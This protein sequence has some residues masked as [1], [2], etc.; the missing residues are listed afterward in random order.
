MGVEGEA[1]AAEADAV[2]ERRG[3]DEGRRARE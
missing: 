1:M 2:Q 3:E